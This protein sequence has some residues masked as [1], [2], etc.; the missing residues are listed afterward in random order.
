M[1]NLTLNYGTTVMLLDKKG[2]QIHTNRHHS[3]CG[4]QCKNKKIHALRELTHSTNIGI[5]Y[6]SQVPRKV[7]D[8]AIKKN[9]MQLTTQAPDPT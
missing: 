4:N 9:P 2:I 7:D 3:L 8:N 6:S 1:V 5:T